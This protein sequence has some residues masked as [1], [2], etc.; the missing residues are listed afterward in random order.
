[1]TAVRLALAAGLLFFCPIASAA[2]IVAPID[3]NSYTVQQIIDAGGIRIGDK[4]FTEW[5]VTT[6][7]QG[8]G[9]APQAGAISVTAVQIGGEYG[10]R[11]NGPWSAA[12][13][14]LA[15]TTI[16]FRATTDDP[17]LICDNSLVLA[18]F[19]ADK[20]GLAS[21]SENVYGADPTKVFTTPVANKYVYYLNDTNNK[22]SD[23]K[24]FGVDLKDIWVLKDVIVNGSTV[25]GATAHISEFYQTFSQIPEPSVLTLLGIGAVLALVRR[26]PRD[27]HA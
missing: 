11:F 10:M 20:G 5:R 18:A 21:I 27:V 16:G 22:T 9:L 6:T 3:G 25:Q 15:D 13:G 14:D 19:G 12:T 23:H 8:N 7:T 4:T 26:G 17:W 24:E 2:I 1:M